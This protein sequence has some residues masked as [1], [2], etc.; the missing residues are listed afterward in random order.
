[1]KLLNFLNKNKYAIIIVILIVYL[2]LMYERIEGFKIEAKYDFKLSRLDELLDKFIG[3]LL[4]TGKNCRGRWTSYSDCDKSCGNGSTQKKTYKILKNAGEGGINCPYEDGYTEARDCYPKMCDI[5][6]KCDENLDCASKNCKDNKC[7]EWVECSFDSLN[8][9]DKNECKNLNDDENYTNEEEGY[10]LYDNSADSCFFKTP[11]EIEEEEIDVFSYEYNTSEPVYK[12]KKCPWYEKLQPDGSCSANELFNN[13][14]PGQFKCSSPMMSPE[15]TI[16]NTESACKYCKLNDEKWTQPEECNCKK[17]GIGAPVQYQYVAGDNPQCLKIDLEKVFQQGNC[18]NG[19]FIGYN[20]RKR[21]EYVPAGKSNWFQKYSASAAQSFYDPCIAFSKQHNTF[22][23]K[24]VTAAHGSFTPD[25]ETTFPTLH[26]AQKTC[27]NLIYHDKSINEL[28]RCGW[29]PIFNNKNDNLIGNC[30]SEQLYNVN[31]FGNFSTLPDSQAGE[32]GKYGTPRSRST[33]ICSGSMVYDDVCPNFI[34]T[35]SPSEH[36]LP[37]YQKESASLSGGS[38]FDSL[39]WDPSR[40]NAS[41]SDFN[42]PVG[43]KICD[44]V[45]EQSDTGL[46][47]CYKD[48]HEKKPVCKPDKKKR[49]KYSVSEYCQSHLQG[50]KRAATTCSKDA[51]ARNYPTTLGYLKNLDG[52]PIPI[53]PASSVTNSPSPSVF[54]KPCS[55]QELIAY[56]SPS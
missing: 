29:Q 16:Y 45:Y 2:F 37:P 34:D 50:V 3:K 22:W 39:Y 56:C 28:I 26:I 14:A 5:S 13:Y 20:I 49:C 4:I 24:S 41:C 10:Y 19:R 35:G 21:G 31:Y 15:P 18:K 52:K 38:N 47:P 48:P 30:N 53:I 27:N 7:S 23:N 51:A 17:N 46:L 36:T 32:L 40:M 9:C 6:D 55:P 33:L 43:I 11:A 12:Y 54:A 44:M 8:M 25:G 1:M 42:S